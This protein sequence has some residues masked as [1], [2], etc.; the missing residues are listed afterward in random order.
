MFGLSRIVLL[1]TGVEFR[2]KPIEVV[3]FNLRL[4]VF[5]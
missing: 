4:T 5:L 3:S 1:E 2:Q